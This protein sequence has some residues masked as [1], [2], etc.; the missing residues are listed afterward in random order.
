MIE[1]VP[2]DIIVCG[3]THIQFD[4]I[5]DD[6]H[7]INAGS[8]RLQSRAYGA[9]WVLLGPLVELKVTPYDTKG[10]SERILKSNSPYKEEF[11]EHYLNPPYEG[12]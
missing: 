2:Q 4:R 7:I 10:A 6:K 12:P 9:C 11:A 8:V 5:V 3:H 1:N